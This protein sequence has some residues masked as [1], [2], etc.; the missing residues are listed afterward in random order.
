MTV[1]KK[2]LIVI[3]FIITVFVIIGFSLPSSYEI[4]R[5]KMIK[6]KA[7]DAYELVQDFKTWP[8]WSPW[9]LSDS[10]MT[11]SYGDITEGVGAKMFWKSEQTG[12]GNQEI[13]SVK[14]NR[15]VET[16]LVY[17]EKGS[18]VSSWEF[19]QQEDS[20]KVVW[21]FGN[22]LGNDIIGRYV[23]L[24]VDRFMGPFFEKGLENVEGVLTKIKEPI[25]EESAQVE[26]K[27]SL[28]TKD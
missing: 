17:G 3:T 27:D 28:L 15:L 9:I 8:E 2:I 7:S 19:I 16:R 11:T 18:A 26:A 13:I 24:A 6:A 10:S 20:V 25:L 23:M 21:T 1:K 14:L 12:S 4:V 22:D 5:I